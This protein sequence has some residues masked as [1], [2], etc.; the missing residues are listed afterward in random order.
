MMMVYCI[1]I[2]SSKII[3]TY[4]HAFYLLTLTMAFSCSGF[5]LSTCCQFV[6]IS[7][8]RD[9]AIDGWGTL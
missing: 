9:K 3:N 2:I 6:L 8:T 7:F 4:H 1:I 5:I